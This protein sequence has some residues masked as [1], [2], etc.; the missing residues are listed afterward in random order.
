MSQQTAHKAHSSV[1]AENCTCAMTGG[2]RPSD[3]GFAAVEF[4][5]VPILLLPLLGLA[6]HLIAALQLQSALDEVSRQAVRAYAVALVNPQAAAATAARLTLADAHARG[7]V[8]IS[9][10]GGRLSV[11]AQVSD[12]G[13]FGTLRGSR[14]VVLQ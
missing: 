11:I 2:M 1:T 10:D 3:A 12:P 5:A 8:T 14:W 4:L 13:W 7:S 6:L 9:S